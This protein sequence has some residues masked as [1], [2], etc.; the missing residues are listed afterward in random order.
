MLADI[1]SI[2]HSLYGQEKGNQAYAQLLTR[3]RGL[4]SAPVGGKRWSPSHQDA[5][6]ITYPDQVTQKGKRPLATLFDFLKRYAEQSISVI[7]ILPF[8]PSTSDDGFSIKDY[9]AVDPSYGN[10]DDIQNLGNSFRL[11]FDAVI[12]HTSASHPWFE[13]YL[14][15]NSEFDRYYISVEGTP[16]LAK[17]VRPRSL[18]LLTS[19][20]TPSGDRRIWTTFSADQVDLNFENPK[21]LIDILDLIMFYVSKGASLMRLDAVAYLWK[22]IGTDCIHRPQTFRIV[23]IIRRMFDEWAPDVQLITETNVPHEDN[24][25]YLGDGYNMSH[26]V[27]NFTLPPLLLYTL[28]SGSC[29]ALNKWLTQLELPIGKVTFLNFLASHDGIGI[30]PLKDVLSADQVEQVLQRTKRLGGLVSYKTDE[31]GHEVP[32]ELNINYFDAL[33]IGEGD[34]RSEG[35]RDLQIE[36]FVCA[37]AILVALKGIPAL[38]FHS[39]F[40]SQGWLDGVKL[41]GRDRTV[42]R[43][44]LKVEDLVK[45]LE[46]PGSNRSRIYNRLVGLLS[47]RA[48]HPAFD[49]YGEQQVVYLS[50]GVFAILRHSEKTPNIVLCLHNI[51]ELYQSVKIKELLIT[52]GLKYFKDIIS[53]R[54]IELEPLGE[55]T[56][57]PYQVY[58]LG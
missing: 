4:Q 57:S 53:N 7:H 28:Q 33:G 38:Y 54:E 12:N 58:W 6:L 52:S 39:L 55:L 31:T 24:L 16:D 48:S 2:L 45:E 27:Y 18:P 40:G 32:Y 8:F 26:M 36:R 22:E 43:Q 13:E 56:L 19:Y 15:G 47:A 29:E 21:V 5:I 46:T 49:P 41:T 25:S 30:N 44:K 42:N 3:L 14:A 20:K 23:Q 9:R 34:K 50:K 17:V 51:T 35:S 37:H 10:W 1:Q 11:M